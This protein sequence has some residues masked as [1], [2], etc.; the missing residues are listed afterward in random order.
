MGC[1]G[2]SEGDDRDAV[3]RSKAL[4]KQLKE[5]AERAAKYVKLLLLGAGE[6]GKSTILKQM[7][8]IH[9]DGYSKEDF[10]QY[11][12]VVYSNTIQSLATIIRA[13]E[14]LSVAFGDQSRERDAGMV[15]D[16]Q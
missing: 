11:R 14:T 3:A 6:S 1:A 13:M 9:M 10:E 8:I 7:K 4:D 5:D 12:E 15:L 2:S 16:K